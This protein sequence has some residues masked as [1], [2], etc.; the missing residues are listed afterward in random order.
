[1]SERAPEPINGIAA[2]YKGAKIGLWIETADA[3]D[4]HGVAMD[5]PWPLTHENVKTSAAGL[6]QALGE[7]L[8]TF[9]V[10]P[11]LNAA[12]LFDAVEQPP[13]GDVL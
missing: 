13:R 10:L 7:L 4:G 9:K 3:S 11:E 12:P 8:A 2:A 1:M 5:A 6:A